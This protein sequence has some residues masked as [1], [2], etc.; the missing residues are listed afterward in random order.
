Y[1]WALYRVI[2]NHEHLNEYAVIIELHEDVVVSNSLDVDKAKFEF[3][4]V[5]TNKFAFNTFQLVRN[6]KNGNSVLGKLIKG[7]SEKPYANIIASLNLVATSNFSLELANKDVDLKIISKEDLSDKQLKDLELELKKE[8]GINELP[9]NLRFIISDIPDSNYQRIL[10]GTIAQLINTLFVGSYTNAESIYTLLID[11]L[12]RKGKVTYDFSKWD[13]L[14]SNKALTS[15]QVTKVINEFTNLKDEAKIE[16]EFNNICSEM[17]LKLI[18][19][20]LLKRSFG[21]Y[22][23]QRISNSSSIQID[24]TNFFVKEIE[25]NMNCGI[26]EMIT[27]IEN[28]YNS[29]TQKILKQF[30]SKD[31][32]TSALICE[33]IMMN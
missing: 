24:T 7:V 12:Y 16:A 14:L 30:A 21:R 18:E 19:T 9:A 1:H 13:E 28:V 3:N 4:Q 31:E 23:R 2:S 20:K 15:I 6:K 25:I 32:F 5:K 27:I 11:E 29:A 17:G 33:Y 8:I 10:I 26:N 22:K